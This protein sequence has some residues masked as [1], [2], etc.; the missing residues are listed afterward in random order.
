MCLFARNCFFYPSPLLCHSQLRR[1]YIGHVEI[2]IPWNRLGS[3]PVEFVV[4]DVFLLVETKYEFTDEE[5]YKRACSV[6][7]AQMRAYELQNT[8]DQNHMSQEYL[9]AGSDSR[10]VGFFSI[11]P[12][13]L[14]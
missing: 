13:I 10:N 5:A 6:K 12:F 11:C 4:D 2:K 1:G 8:L 9:R 3:E 7:R 14:A